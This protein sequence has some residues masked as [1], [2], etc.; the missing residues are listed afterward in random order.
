MPCRP[1][2]G[3]PYEDVLAVAAGAVAAQGAGGRGGEQ[4]GGR[5]GEEGGAEGEVQEALGVHGQDT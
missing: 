4:G 2:D 1:V 3:L 5:Q